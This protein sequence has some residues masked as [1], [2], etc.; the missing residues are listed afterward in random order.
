[1]LFDKFFEWGLLI[2]GLLYIADM[3]FDSIIHLIEVNNDIEERDEAK[4]K[5]E[6]E[7]EKLEK[8]TQHL[9]S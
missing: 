2:L 6:N 8:L 4:A 1:M 3:Y 9:Y 7:K 5:E